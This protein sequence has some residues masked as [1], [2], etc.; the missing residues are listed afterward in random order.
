MIKFYSNDQ[1]RSKII[2][3]LVRYIL[4]LVIVNLTVVWGINRKTL[5]KPIQKFNVFVSALVNDELKQDL[6]SNLSDSIYEINIYTFG[7]DDKYYNSYYSIYG[8]GESDIIISPSQDGNAI[9]NNFLPLNYSTNKGLN[10]NDKLYGLEVFDQESQT[11]LLQKYLKSS[12]DSTLYAFISKKSVHASDD[13]NLAFEIM[14]SVFY[15]E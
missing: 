1:V 8:P 13:S 10:V 9:I 7:L 2:R 5:P 3:S 12:V 11:G 6:R 14:R 4:F 15:E